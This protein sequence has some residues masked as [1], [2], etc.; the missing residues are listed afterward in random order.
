MTELPDYP[1]WHQALNFMVTGEPRDTDPALLEIE[2]TAAEIFGEPAPAHS[3]TLE[4]ARNEL[5]RRVTRGIAT[6]IGQRR[7]A[8]GPSAMSTESLPKEID[9]LAVIN[10]KI[11]DATSDA[12]IAPLE[13]SIPGQGYANLR[14]PSEDVRA[15]R[16]AVL[17]EMARQ[18]EEQR[19][20]AGLL[21]EIPVPEPQTESPPPR[22]KRL[23]ES[24]VKDWI[25]QRAGAWTKLSA[26]EQTES[27]W[28]GQGAMR[29]SCKDELGGNFPREPFNDLRRDKMEQYGIKRPRSGRR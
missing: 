23:S 16:E 13:A 5:L 27:P 20:L 19:A 2:H 1:L 4:R 3:M 10:L 25:D 6:L 21:V 7:E 24:A 26:E 15:A 18:R 8:I 14:L 22:G 12:T 28:P 11:D 9:P 29:R 17:A